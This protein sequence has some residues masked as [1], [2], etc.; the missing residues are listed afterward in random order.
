MCLFH[1]CLEDR[2]QEVGD[3]HRARGT[4]LVDSHQYLLEINIDGDHL[5]LPLVLETNMEGAN[6]LKGYVQE[7][8][9][10]RESVQDR[11]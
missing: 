2:G 1:L 8:E 3:D 5:S 4:N 7:P 10:Q 6:C 9:V 11:L